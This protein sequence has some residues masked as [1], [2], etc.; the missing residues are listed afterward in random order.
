[1]DLQRGNSGADRFFRSG[2]EEASEAKWLKARKNLASSYEVGRLT[3]T[4]KTDI[5]GCR[6]IEKPVSFSPLPRI[7]ERRFQ[8]YI[9]EKKYIYPCWLEKKHPTPMSFQKEKPISF[10]LMDFL[11][12]SYHVIW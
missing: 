7:P 11:E 1:M 3:L 5:D 8:V 6:K 10:P 4:G 2:G 12:L 9:Y